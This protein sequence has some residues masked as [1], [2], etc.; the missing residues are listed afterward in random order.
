M[1]NKFNSFSFAKRGVHRFGLT[2]PKRHKCLDAS[3]LK[4]ETEISANT[5]RKD[6]SDVIILVKCNIAY[7]IIC[8]T[9]RI[10]STYGEWIGAWVCPR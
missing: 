10:L 3:Y 4:A 8:K 9:E 5:K 1:Y 6:G 2:H 7:Y